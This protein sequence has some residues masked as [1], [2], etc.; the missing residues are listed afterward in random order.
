MTAMEFIKKLR[1]K[2]IA[3]NYSEMSA[4]EYFETEAGRRILS[5]FSHNIE[6]LSN[7]SFRLVDNNVLNKLEHKPLYKGRNFFVDMEELGFTYECTAHHID[8]APILTYEFT[9]KE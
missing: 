7:K 3:G 9:I 6:I 8:E 1:G 4:K 5:F 2:S